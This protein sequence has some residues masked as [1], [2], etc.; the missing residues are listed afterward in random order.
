MRDQKQTRYRSNEEQ[1]LFIGCVN[2]PKCYI[3]IFFRYEYYTMSLDYVV[4][5]K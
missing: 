2:G 5:A 3:Y 1:Y 4:C